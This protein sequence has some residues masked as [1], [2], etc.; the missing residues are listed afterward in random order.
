MARKLKTENHVAIYYEFALVTKLNRALFDFDNARIDRKE[1]EE[2][3]NKGV[4]RANGI[5]LN[6]AIAPAAIKFLVKSDLNGKASTFAY[7]VKWYIREYLYSIDEQYYKNKGGIWTG[8]YIC[9]SIGNPI[10]QEE[11]NAYLT[12]AEQIKLS[13]QTYQ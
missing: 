3:I 13:Y 10:G 9:K 11:L 12:E 7:Y 4:A 1:L 2:A 5:C 6:I 8:G